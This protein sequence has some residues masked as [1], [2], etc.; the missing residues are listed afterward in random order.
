[1]TLAEACITEVMFVQDVFPFFY[2][3]IF[4]LLAIV[5]FMVF[6]TNNALLKTYLFSRLFIGSG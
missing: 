4:E 6:L 3:L 5:Q 1:M 2:A